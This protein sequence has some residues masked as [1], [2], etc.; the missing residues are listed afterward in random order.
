MGLALVAVPFGCGYSFKRESDIVE[1][2]YSASGLRVVIVTNRTDTEGT[3]FVEYL[4]KRPRGFRVLDEGDLIRYWES[5]AFRADRHLYEVTS[6]GWKA[7]EIE[8]AGM[9]S[10]TDDVG[11]YR[12]WFIATTNRCANVLSVREPEIREWDC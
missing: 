4:F 11:G 8:I 7:Q 1:L 5:G 9:L 3:C 2:S 10:V 6:G 12:E